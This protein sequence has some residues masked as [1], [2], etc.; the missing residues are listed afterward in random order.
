MYTALKKA[1]YEANISLKNSGLVLFTWGNVS[2]R[3]PNLKVIAI[4]PSGVAYET[5][6][7]DDIVVVDYKGKI[8]E[9]TLKPSVDLPTHLKLYEEHPEIMS[10]VHTH[11]TFATAWAQKGRAIP[12]YGTT[13]AD[14]FSDAIPCAEFLSE[15]E[16]VAYEKNTGVKLNEVIQKG[17]ALDIPA[18]IVKGHGAFA[19]GKNTV[20]AVYHATV[21]EEVAKMAYLTE[22]LPGQNVTLPKHIRK[23]HYERKHGPHATYGQEKK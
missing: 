23:T 16:M 22:T 3:D 9:G 13:H 6:S 1:V 15:L 14:Y 21:L 17:H 5:M 7:V 18:A 12:M 2:G 8:I 11:S 10:I 19:W 4:K 20:E